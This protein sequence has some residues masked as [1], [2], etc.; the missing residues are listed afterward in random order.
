VLVGLPG[1]GKTTV[2]QELSRVWGV[3]AVDTDE[4]VS[5]AV[6]L[7]VP[8]YLR[9][10]GETQ[11]RQREFEA[12]GTALKTDAVVSTGGGVVTLQ[13]ARHALATSVTYWLDCS[14]E[15]ILVRVSDGDRPLL[16][17]DP[18]GSLALLR[19]RRAPWYQEV[20]IARVDSSGTLD[21]VVARVLDELAR[22]A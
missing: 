8:D 5:Q 17:E 19:A 20:S 11:F 13:E 16:G 2:A 3:E 7:A 18:A 12:L 4:L 15:D 14:D 6:G 10:F 1:T 9:A 22:T 21:E